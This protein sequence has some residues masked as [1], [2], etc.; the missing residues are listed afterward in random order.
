MPHRRSFLKTSVALAAGWVAMPHEHG[1]FTVAQT[2]GTTTQPVV[3]R[4]KSVRIG[5]PTFFSEA[6]PDAWAKNAREQRYRAVYAPNVALS[7]TDRIKAFRNTAEQHDLFI[8]EVGRWSVIR[9]SSR[10]SVE[11]EP[12]GS[13]SS[14]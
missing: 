2:S 5:A 4:N 9:F 1:A 14:A 10:V 13:S 8:A 3:G 12:S 7:D 11:A 6:A